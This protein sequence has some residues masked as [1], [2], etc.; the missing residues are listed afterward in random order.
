[1]PADDHLHPDQYRGLHQPDLQGP[2]IHD[3]TEMFPEDVYTHPHYY[4]HGDRKIDRH[5]G[6]VLVTARGRPDAPIDVYRAVPRG[7]STINSGDWVT[8]VPD[9]ARQHAMHPTDP[10]LD[11]P[12]LHAQVP[13][14]HVRTGGNDIIEWGYSGP[15]IEGR[16]I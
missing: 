16:V 13:A 9:Y 15:D 7:V 11:W 2:A 3:L 4:G 6:R 14:E 8:T 5:A 12:V 1:M 10:T